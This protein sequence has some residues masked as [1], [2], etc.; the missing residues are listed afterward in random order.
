MTNDNNDY[1]EHWKTESP[2]KVL[3]GCGR[4]HTDTFQTE[5]ATP[6]TA[7][8]QLKVVQGESRQAI[9]HQRPLLSIH[10]ASDWGYRV[11]SPRQPLAFC[12]LSMMVGQ[13]QQPVS[14][15][16]SWK[17]AD[18]P[19]DYKVVNSGMKRQWDTLSYPSI[20]VP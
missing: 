20:N 9:L 2:L 5:A 17:L 16:D 13:A 15:L 19:K 8:P 1:P 12:S 3:L 10:A 11:L 18:R 7:W 14:R 6:K 4:L